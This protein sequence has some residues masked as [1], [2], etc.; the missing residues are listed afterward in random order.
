[1][2][3]HGFGCLRFH[4]LRFAAEPRGAESADEAGGGS[5][6]GRAADARRHHLDE[7]AALW[8]QGRH[9]RLLPGAARRLGEKLSALSGAGPAGSDGLAFAGIEFRGTGAA[10]QRHSAVA[11][12]RAV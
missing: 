4:E 6:G 2:G 10:R 5:G 9:D 7:H 1:L 11:R 3:F 8:L 12:L